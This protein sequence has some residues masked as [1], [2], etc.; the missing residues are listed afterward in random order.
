MWRRVPAL[1]LFLLLPV[2][3]GCWDRRELEEYAF[4]LAIGVDRGEVSPYAITLMIARPERMAGGGEKG[5]GGGGEEKPYLLTTVDAPTIPAA[6]SMVNSTI[7]RRV[8]LLHT[9]TLLMGEAL[10]RE[11]GMQ[12]MDEFARYREARRSIAYIVTRGKA[13]DFLKEMDP[14]I[15]KDPHKFLAEMGATGYYTGMLPLR[16]QINTFITHAHTGYVSPITYYASLKEDEEAGG[17][18]TGEKKDS[19]FVAG[20]LPRKGGPNLE[21]IGA[22]AFRREQM[23][24]VLNGEEVRMILMLQDQ[25][26]RGFFSIRDPLAPDQ[27]VSLELERSRPTMI[28]VE[29]LGQRPRIRARVRLE[30]EVMAIQSKID[31]TDPARQPELERALRSELTR[32]MREAI[33]KTQEWGSDVPGFGRAVVRHFP[34]IAAWEEY[35]WPGRY[36]HAEVIP[37]IE[38]TLRRF[39]LQL[40]PP[41]AID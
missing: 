34:T 18:R 22:A 23:T 24:G 12:T 7:N 9:K 3:S 40:S 38:V 11:S 21:M 30:G 2:L 19:G 20:E 16:G 27:F 37:E 14:K 36:R 15:E 1:L 28:L 33:G 31:Y 41:N 4:V 5:G 13:S 25:F 6:I 10:A 32:M 8:S 17:A 35:D 26:R 29:Q 39:G